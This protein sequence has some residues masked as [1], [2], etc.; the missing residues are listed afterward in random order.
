MSVYKLCFSVANFNGP[1]Y[2]TLLEDGV[3]SYFLTYS[4]YSTIWTLGVPT[5]PVLFSSTTTP[6][7]NHYIWFDNGNNPTLCYYSTDG[8]STVAH[9]FVV[10]A[11]ARDAVL[12]LTT[13]NSG[14]TNSHYNC[15]ESSNPASHVL[16]DTYTENGDSYEFTFW[17]EQNAA[18]EYFPE[19]C[20]F[21]DANHP[22]LFTGTLSTGYDSFIFRCFADPTLLGSGLSVSSIVATVDGSS[23]PT[24]MARVSSGSDYWETALLTL[25][26]PTKTITGV[27]TYYIP[28]TVKFTATLSDNSTL[29]SDTYYFVSLLKNGPT[30]PEKTF[31]QGVY[32]ANSHWICDTPTGYYND[33]GSLVALS[34][35]NDA[36]VSLVEG[37]W[38]S[39]VTNLLTVSAAGSYSST[40]G[41]IP[42]DSNVLFYGEGTA[43]ISQKKLSISGAKIS[44]KT[45]NA[46]VSAPVNLASATVDGIASGD[47]VTVKASG[48][49]A[50]Y[51]YGN[52]KDAL[53]TYSLEGTDKD[54]YLPPDS[55]TLKGNINRRRLTVNAENITI[56][57]KDYDG[58]TRADVSF[59]TFG[60][61]M[62]V[63]IGKV[64]VSAV[65]TFVTSASS[66][67]GDP[68]VGENKP[69]RIVFSV[70]AGAN[71]D[72]SFCYA[73]PNTNS[74][75]TADI[76]ARPINIFNIQ[77]QSN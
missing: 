25:V 72:R 37:A 73:A 3:V 70:G 46:N 52:Q 40:V 59:S 9:T 11:D 44:T 66:S 35:G 56:L 18:P 76:N 47:D 15:V 5:T 33:S 53:V 22:S 65:G 45:Y 77:S 61:T 29:E 36:W 63:D 23:I 74:S 55:E 60:N 12:K 64:S 17:S 13:G 39:I 34:E 75:L 14:E 26:Q 43:I 57:D 16:G 27:G 30:T 28:H 49:Y 50:D 62:S 68:N 51:D 1:A 2:L 48:V 31:Y 24:Q 6:V 42:S 10:T 8:G 67:T 41:Y 32:D 71:G 54:N 7:V 4:T 58:T 19:L 69:V 20:R 21:D 38:T